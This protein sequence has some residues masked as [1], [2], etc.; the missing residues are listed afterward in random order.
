M[1]DTSCNYFQ[2]HPCRLPLR[3]FFPFH[4][5]C[6]RPLPLSVASYVSYRTPRL[7]CAHFLF[8]YS[9]ARRRGGRTTSTKR[10]KLPCAQVRSKRR[11][12]NNNNQRTISYNYLP[13]CR[14]FIFVPAFLA[15][16]ILAVAALC[17]FKA[18]C[19]LL[20]F[21]FNCVFHC[22]QKICPLSFLPHP[23]F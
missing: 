2:P 19:L 6:V 15:V 1:C 5:P 12:R 9:P 8:L 13:L 3:P 21:F 11:S 7:C 4:A 17:L 10:P 20:S 23:L 18:L 16:A 22:L 14:A